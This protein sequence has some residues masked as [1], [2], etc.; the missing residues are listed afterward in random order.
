MEEGAKLIC[1]SDRWCSFTPKIRSWKSSFGWFD[2][3]QAGGHD[4]ETPG[5]DVPSPES[6]F[7]P[8]WGRWRMGVYMK[9]AVAVFEEPKTWPHAD[10]RE[11]KRSS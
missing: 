5:E 6:N 11:V 4:N 3:Q 2:M 1:G 8:G 10:A 9:D 7:W